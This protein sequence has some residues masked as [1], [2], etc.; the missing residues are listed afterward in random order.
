MHHLLLR[1]A[2]VP[3][4]PASVSAVWLCSG[5]TPYPAMGHLPFRFNDNLIHTFFKS[6]GPVAWCS[7]C[8]AATLPPLPSAHTHHVLL[9]ELLGSDDS[10]YPRDSH[11]PRPLLEL[12]PG[13][14]TPFPPS[15]ILQ[16]SY[17]TRSTQW[18]SSTASSEKPSQPPQPL[19][20]HTLSL[21]IRRFLLHTHCLLARPPS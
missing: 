13:P 19:S 12:L 6:P 16:M 2:R 11:A 9:L 5:C 14:G 15:L 21:Q 1:G 17:W 18:C 4:W 7:P 3:V 8:S 10:E 20:G